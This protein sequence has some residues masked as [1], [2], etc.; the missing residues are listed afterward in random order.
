MNIVGSTD[1][2]VTLTGN[3][4]GSGLHDITTYTYR[5]GFYDGVEKQYR[6]FEEV[7]LRVVSSDS[8]EGGI[9]EMLYDVGREKPHYNGL[10]LSQKT[11]SGDR[12][13]DE[14]ANLYTECELASDPLSE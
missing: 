14:Q 6:G 11:T 1:I 5:N 4:D 9:T 8:Q 10:L 13:I 2:F 7:E 3:E 12:D